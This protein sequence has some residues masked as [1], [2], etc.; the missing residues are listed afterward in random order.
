MEKYSFQ[1]MFIFIIVLHFFVIYADNKSFSVL[2]LESRKPNLKLRSWNKR[3]RIGVFRG[4]GLL[5][6]PILGFYLSKNL[7]FTII[8]SYLICS[9]ISSIVTFYQFK[10]LNKTILMEI[11]NDFQINLKII[12]LIGLGSIGFF[13]L[14]HV[15][16]LTNI[17]AY[18][19]E[20][21]AL[22][23]VQITPFLTAISTF[24]MIF[25]MDKKIAKNLDYGQIKYKNIAQILLVRFFGR[26]MNLI[27]SVILIIILKNG[28]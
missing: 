5:I 11:K 3:E 15:H 8:V 21:H 16:F 6:P 24:Y 13:F 18:Y 23:L 20:T 22:W 26:L 27:L 10:N 19:F 4:I 9:I 2:V 28:I 14:Y 25:I 12:L 17:L 7:I 1:A